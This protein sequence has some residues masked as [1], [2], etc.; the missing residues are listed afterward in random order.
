[1]TGLP[2]RLRRLGGRGSVRGSPCGEPARLRTGLQGS[3]PSDPGIRVPLHPPRHRSPPSPYR[4]G[5]PRSGASPEAAHRPSRCSASAGTEPW[6]PASLC[7][8]SSC[9]GGTPA[10]RSSYWGAPPPAATPPDPIASPAIQASEGFSMQVVRQEGVTLR[11]KRF[12][13]TFLEVV[14]TVV[15]GVSLAHNPQANITRCREEV[16]S[17]YQHFFLDSAGI[18]AVCIQST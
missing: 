4:I 17:H 18:V 8:R 6:R 7:P 12:R 14:G 15:G 13:G 2:V 9:C 1:V 5:T 10:A 3:I 16:S 11:C